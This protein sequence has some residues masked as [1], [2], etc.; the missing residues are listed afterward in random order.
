M[1]VDR[2]A[3]P[4]PEWVSAAS[5]SEF[6]CAVATA[7]GNDRA[8]RVGLLLHR[9]DAPN[10]PITLVLDAMASKVNGLLEA[11]VRSSDAQVALRKA[12]IEVVNEA[13][14]MSCGIQEQWF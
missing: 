10:H 14:S 9:C 4:V 11:M 12:R 6:R 1:F 3:E 5:Y 13:T 2:G 8:R 7:R